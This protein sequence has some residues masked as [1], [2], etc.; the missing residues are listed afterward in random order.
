MK[1]L[2]FIIVAASFLIS[3]CQAQ[4]YQSINSELAQVKAL[5]EG[6]NQSIESEITEKINEKIPTQ[7]SVVLGKVTVNNSA[8]REGPENAK[9][10]IEKLFTGEVVKIYSVSD[11]SKWFFVETA[12]GTQGWINAQQVYT[13]YE[14]ENIAKELKDNQAQV[15]AFLEIPST[16]TPEPQPTLKP[17][18][19]KLAPTKAAPTKKPSNDTYKECSQVSA[20][21][22][23]TCKISRAYCSYESGV[24]GQPTFC[25]DAPYPSNNFT[26]LV[27]GKDWSKFNGKCLL[28]SGYI[29]LYK[30]KA[31]IEATSESQ[32]KLCP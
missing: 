31:Q 15:F 4:A 19:T 10:V 29:S 20:G 12:I 22:N 25:N 30:G 27:W 26:L 11:D 21:S 28:V 2:I 18:S 6:V 17:A 8:V 32:V 3:S 23:T 7:P 1:K 5:V 14:V 24:K 9:E 16:S 13:N